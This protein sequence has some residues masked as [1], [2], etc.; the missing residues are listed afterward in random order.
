[1]IALVVIFALT[2]NAAV[3]IGNEVGRNNRNS[4]KLVSLVNIGIGL[5]LISFFSLS[6]LIFPRLVIGIDL[7]IN[8]PQLQP[9]IDTA[10]SFLS[11]IA[12]LLITDCIR[13]IS[14]GSLRGL[15][16]TRFPMYVSILGFWIIG[17]SSAYLLAFKLNFGGAGIWWG[18]VIGLFITGMILFVR[19]NKLV[20]YI[21][22]VALVTKSNG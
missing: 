8:A 15:K 12:V 1:M 20:K 10:V 19:F 21:D 18:V 22:L 14:M 11:I 3:R 4:L 6:Y 2:Q 5:V 13:L 7:D 16:D 9:L 17:F